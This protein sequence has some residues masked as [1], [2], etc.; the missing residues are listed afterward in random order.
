MARRVYVVDNFRYDRLVH[1]GCDELGEFLKLR[2]QL[3]SADF[4]HLF[5]GFEPPSAEVG[6]MPRGAHAL[7]GPNVHRRVTNQCGP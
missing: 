7:Q 6:V 4:M 1:R 3:T 5:A 2:K